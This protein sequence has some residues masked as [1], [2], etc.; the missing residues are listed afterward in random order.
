MALAWYGTDGHTGYDRIASSGAITPVFAGDPRLGNTGVGEK[1]LD[2]GPIGI[3]AF[4]E[5]GPLQQPYDF[6]YPGRWNFDL[7]VFK[8]FALGG[9]RRL[10]LRLGLF[11]L[12][13][14]AAP[15][16]AFGD[17]DLD[18]HTECNVRVDGVP[19]GAGGTADGVCDPTQGFYFTEVARENFGRI[20]AKR[21]HR[22]IELAVRFDF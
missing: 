19:N 10:Q 22:V 14:Q 3:P 4:A 6:R 15:S 18:L 21:G 9:R 13:N 11:N 5:T 1:V 16:P 7:S 20:K 2:L 8:S 12:F 17:I